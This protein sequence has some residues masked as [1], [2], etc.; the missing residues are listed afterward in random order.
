M[1]YNV[2]NGILSLVSNFIVPQQRIAPSLAD[3]FIGLD[4]ASIIEELNEYLAEL[5][6]KYKN[7]F[8]ADVNGIAGSMGKR[9]FLD[10]TTY[11][12]SHGAIFWP[13]W[14]EHERMP[15]WT[16]PNPG[17]IE[18]IPPINSFY[19][20]R[21]EEFFDCVYRQL[22]VRYRTATQADQVKLVIF[23][24][25]NTLWRGQIAEHYRAG[26]GNW[27]YADGWPMG[28]WEAVHHLRW[29]GILT[30]ICS[31]ND[32]EIVK[33]NWNNVF[34]LGWLELDDFV[35]PKINWNPK[36]ENIRDIMAEVGLTPKSVLF[37]DDNPVE[38]EAVK[39]AFPAMRVIGS[40]PFL[41]RRILLWSAET[42]VLNLTDESKNRETM[43][44]KQFLRNDAKAA[45]PREE[46]LSGLGCK[47]RIKQLAK[48][49]QPEYTRCLELV[50]KTNQFNT[51]GERWRAD[52]FAKFVNEGQGRVYSFT[53]SDKF[54]NYGLVGVLITQDNSI[55]QFVMS[56]R[57][58]GM[59][60]EIA[61]IREITE[62]LRS[63]TDVGF[64]TA[65]LLETNENTP[66]R[67]V[68]VKSGFVGNS[69]DSSVFVLPDLQEPVAADH[70][71]T[72]EILVSRHNF[73]FDKW[74][75]SR[76]PDVASANERG[77]I[78]SAEYHYRMYGKE[79][80]RFCPDYL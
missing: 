52:E 50:N 67:Q 57:V 71:R 76:Y 39:S 27:P 8:I 6:S 19:E 61:V 48:A 13:D 10:D 1:K 54:V 24:L 80:S 12:Y 55:R 60:I 45:L 15:H 68:Y 20:N 47:L 30:S 2:R 37:I 17:R 25:D 22:V 21:N 4:I 65:R 72:E 38:R 14:H 66:C 33:Q 32:H 75:L 70:V 26:L 63:S 53:V 40:N 29:R 7:A 78:A 69:A 41:T 34:E 43:V 18:E 35:C 5:V 31:K 28:L 11:F 64:I 62:L 74:Y 58:L 36:A 44:K 23:D 16:A 73:N 56:C 79:E 51:T 49:D 59:E 42:R 9:Y 77:I 46:F 3:D